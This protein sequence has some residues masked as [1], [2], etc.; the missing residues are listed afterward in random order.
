ME[1]KIFDKKIYKEKYKKLFSDFIKKKT[2]KVII[3]DKEYELA[4]FDRRIFASSLDALII[5]FVTQ[6]ISIITENITGLGRKRQE[7]IDSSLVPPVNYGDVVDIVGNAM[8]DN[9]L[10]G[11]VSNFIFYQ[12]IMI[13][14]IMVLT[15]IC[16]VKWSKT[17]GKMLLRCCVIDADT[18]QKMSKKQAIIRCFSIIISIGFFGLGL[19]GIGFSKRRRSL[20][21]YFANTI[22][23]LEPKK[24]ISIPINNTTA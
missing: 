6:P 14:V 18:G 11:I 24:K 23:I 9:I 10:S 13:V 5:S 12:L 19:I 20:H 2:K 7:I 21:D 1:N 22:V 15:I 8:K 3:N 4:S 17:P 16:W